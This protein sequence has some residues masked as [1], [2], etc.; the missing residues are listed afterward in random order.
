VIHRLLPCNRFR[1]DIDAEFYVAKKIAE[2][3][4]DFQQNGRR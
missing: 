2:V 1:E 4:N 3:F